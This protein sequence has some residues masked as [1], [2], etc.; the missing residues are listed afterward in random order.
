MPRLNYTRRRTIDK[1]DV[2]LLLDERADGEVRIR[3]HIAVHDAA[4]LPDSASVQLYIC[5]SPYLRRTFQIG[6]VRP[7]VDVDLSLGLLPDANGLRSDVRIIDLDDPSRRILAICRRCRLTG[8]A[9]DG[10]RRSGLLGVRRGDFAL[11]LWRLSLD[12]LSGE[13]VW[14]EVSK[15]IPDFRAFARRSEVQSL[16]IPE[17][18]RQVAWKVLVED[19][20]NDD[21]DDSTPSAQWVRWFFALPGV[22]EFE[23]DARRDV[24]E[25]WVDDICES[26]CKD[27]DLARRAADFLDSGDE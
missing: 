16:V 15:R 21:P 7:R 13:G 17:A 8:S 11:P 1:Q 2:R 20:F 9:D 4:E 24:R 12:E 6:P 3:G 5:R 14:L 23:A 22:D 25:R 26:F 18:V 27:C 19:E 10:E